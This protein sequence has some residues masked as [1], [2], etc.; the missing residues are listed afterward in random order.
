MVNKIENYPWSSYQHNALG[1]VDE[2]IVE[3]LQ[4]KKLGKDAQLRCKNYK[5]LFD[6]LKSSEQDKLVTDATMRGVVYGAE[7]FHRKIGKLISH[8][9]KL[10][11]HGGDRKSETFKNQAATP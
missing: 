3:H 2:L 9:T 8:P 4:Y 11:T 7:R 5:S 1:A 10:V 6:K